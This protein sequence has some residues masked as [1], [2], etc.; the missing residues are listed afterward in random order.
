MGLTGFY[1]CRLCGQPIGVSPLCNRCWEL[2]R[3]IQA[4]PDLA[5]RILATLDVANENALASANASE[6]P[7]SIRRARDGLG[8]LFAGRCPRRAPRP[9]GARFAHKLDIDA[10]ARCSLD[11]GHAGPCQF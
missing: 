4:D 6:I 1:P 3:R 5:R 8:R 2:E 11:A 9:P 7:S 10:D